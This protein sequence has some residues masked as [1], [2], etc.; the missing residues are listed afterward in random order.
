MSVVRDLDNG[1]GP[2]GGR[3]THSQYGVRL[4]LYMPK[5]VHAALA[6][7]AASE[8]RSQNAVV[9]EILGRC[10]GETCELSRLRRLSQ[11]GRRVTLYLDPQLAQDLR[12]RSVREAVSVSALVSS[13]LKSA[14]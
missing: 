5:D 10:V 2:R 13:L 11:T 6:E 4:S 14:L 12:L 1:I 8:G 9:A 7:R 3:S